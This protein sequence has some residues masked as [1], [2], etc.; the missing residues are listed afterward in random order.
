MRG[1]IQA[2]RLITCITAYETVQNP[3]RYS[4]ELWDNSMKLQYLRARWYDPSV[5][6]FINEDTYEGEINNPLSLNL[7][8]YV[9]NNPL[10]YV[11]PTGH[12]PYYSY[13][14]DVYNLYFSQKPYEY[15]KNSMG[16][17]PFVGGWLS[18][19]LSSSIKALTQLI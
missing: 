1:R 18:D 12:K 16:A 6:S 5:G 9:H 15:K 17:I 7:Y 10:I 11:D 2:A 14:N 8:T 3:F 4:R 19:I 13:Y